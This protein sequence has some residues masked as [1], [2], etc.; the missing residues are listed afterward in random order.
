M[1]P[2]TPPPQ[3][4][5]VE[6]IPLVE[7]LIPVSILHFDIDIVD[8]SLA[9]KLARRSPQ[10][11]CNTVRLLRCI[12]SIAMSPISIHNI[13]LIIKTRKMQR[14]LVICQEHVEHVYPKNVHQL[15]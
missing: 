1:D 3:G 14:H 7:D 10:K 5:C 8:G 6:D 12:N 9:G 11:F 4:V 15:R 2:A 13:E